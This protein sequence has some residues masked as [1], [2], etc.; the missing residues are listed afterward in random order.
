MKKGFKAFGKGMICLKKQYK[1]NTKYKI[2]SDPILCKNGFHYCENPLDILDYYDIC[3]SE[4]A[5]VE[6]LGN[7]K[8]DGTKSV[9]DYIKINSKLDLKG[10]IKVSIDHIWDSCHD[11]DSG[12]LAASGDYS[13][14]SASGK[15]SKLAASGYNSKLAASGDH[16]KLAASGKNSICAA[17][18]RNSVAKGIIGTWLVLS[19]HKDNGEVICVKSVKIDGKKIKADTYYSLKNGKFIES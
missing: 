9:T 14:L 2:K 6:D 5:E 1:E 4:F 7:T 10:F 15:N 18:G 3:D 13:Q 16:S 12:K 17:I 8:S 19:E 11:K